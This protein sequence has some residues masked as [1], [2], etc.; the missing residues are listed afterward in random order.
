M[1]ENEKLAEV[2]DEQ[3]PE[4]ALEELTDGKGEDDE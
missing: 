2:T 1:K 4:T 3:I